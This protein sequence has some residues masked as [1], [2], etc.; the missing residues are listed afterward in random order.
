M[1]YAVAPYHSKQ[2]Q[3][4]QFRSIY[5]GFVNAE[6]NYQPQVVLGGSDRLPGTKEANWHLMPGFKDINLKTVLA[7]FENSLAGLE[8]IHKQGLVHMDPWLEIKR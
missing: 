2:C 8:A 1:I 7:L 4:H 6:T 3:T 5:L